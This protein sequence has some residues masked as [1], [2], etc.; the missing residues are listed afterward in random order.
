MLNLGFISIKTSDG[1]IFL[2]VIFYFIELSLFGLKLI[3]SSDF[4]CSFVAMELSTSL[5]LGSLFLLSAFIFKNSSQFALYPIIYIFNLILVYIHPNFDS[6]FPY[7]F[8]KIL[9]TVLT[10][11]R[12][13][14][15]LIMWKSLRNIFNWNNFLKYKSDQ[16]LIG[17]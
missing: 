12:G 14:L 8:F 7:N 16:K 13:F 15:I 4:G 5:F 1:V 9:K 6:N 11:I 2:F 10:S 17:K 3:S